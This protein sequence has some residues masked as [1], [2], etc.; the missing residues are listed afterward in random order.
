MYAIFTD[1][2]R[3]YKVEQGQNLDID[4]RDTAETGDSIVFDN[5]LAIGGAKVA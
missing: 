4:L 5:V 3:Q 1:G 2:G